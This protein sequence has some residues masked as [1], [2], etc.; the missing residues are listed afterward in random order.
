MRSSRQLSNRQRVASP[1]VADCAYETR[2]DVGEQSTDTEDTPDIAA[3]DLTVTAATLTP[4][5]EHIPFR[6]LVDR[7]VIV[8]GGAS[9]AFA[10]RVS[11]VGG[12]IDAASVFHGTRSYW[13]R[14]PRPIPFDIKEEAM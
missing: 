6:Q 7:R 4:S 10:D 1:Q 5:Q 2:P 12:Q 13:G 9:A 14:Q 3:L 8:V 11:D